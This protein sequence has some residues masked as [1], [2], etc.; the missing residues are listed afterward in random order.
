MTLTIFIDQ[1]KPCEKCGM[2][3]A[4]QNGLCLNCI[5]KKIKEQRK[6][7]TMAAKGQQHLFGDQD[8][9][10]NTL[11]TERSG[12]Q[13]EIEATHKAIESKQEKLD[14][15]EGRVHNIILSLESIRKATKMD[16]KKETA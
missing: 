3:G 1:N 10:I 2:M 5:S 12:L 15:L 11:E 6:G 9:V 16:K 7:G 4:T 13:K 14:D 8:F